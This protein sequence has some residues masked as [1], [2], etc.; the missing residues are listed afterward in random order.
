MLEDIS[1]FH[2]TV[3]FI[4]LIRTF[5]LVINY[6]QSNGAI[7]RQFVYDSASSKFYVT[8]YSYS[9]IDIFDTSCSLLQSINLG[10]KQPHGLAFFT[11][12]IYA[13][14]FKSNQVI[15]IQN[16]LVSKYFTV[17]QFDNNNSI[18]SIT[19]DTFGYLALTCTASN[20]I[21]VYD[22]NGNY[23]NASLTTSASPH[24]SAIDSSGRF[25]IMTSKSLDIYY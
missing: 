6:Y 4:K 16:G 24:I 14:V 21:V 13:G 20:Q 15:V 19:V 18:L 8:V 23:M 1:T 22:A 10:S 12:N 17:N 2:Q 11:A 9:R 7:Y 3:I 25:V 5:F